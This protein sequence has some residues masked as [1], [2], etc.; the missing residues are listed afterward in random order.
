MTPV[1]SSA[2]SDL[3]ASKLESGI[4]EG[5]SRIAACFWRRLSLLMRCI[6]NAYDPRA[7]KVHPDRQMSI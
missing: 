6:V 4:G 7:T 3:M 5:L 2:G 1:H